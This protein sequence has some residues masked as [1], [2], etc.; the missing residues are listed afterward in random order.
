MRILFIALLALL[1]FMAEAKPTL[2]IDQA[3]FE[4]KCLHRGYACMYE[5]IHVTSK[6]TYDATTVRY[7]FIDNDAEYNDIVMKFVHS[8]RGVVYLEVKGDTKPVKWFVVNDNPNDE[9]QKQA[10]KS[11]Y[12]LLARFI[13]NE[14]FSVPSRVFFDISEDF[15]SDPREMRRIIVE[16]SR[17]VTVYAE[18]INHNIHYYRKTHPPTDTSFGGIMI[19]LDGW[20]EDY[21]RS[22]YIITTQPSWISFAKQYTQA[23][24]VLEIGS[25]RLPMFSGSTKKI[26]QQTVAWMA[27]HLKATY[28]MAYGTFPNKSVNDVLNYGGD[29]CK[30]LDLIFRQILKRSG[31]E[32][33]PSAISS[34]GMPP[35]SYRLIDPNWA[36]HVITYIPKLES[37]VDIT[38][39]MNDPAKWTE[40]ASEYTGATT[41]DLQTGRFAI[42]NVTRHL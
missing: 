20:T 25:D 2:T 12:P 32:S 19:N 40:S 13:S 36:D 38:R 22:F 15:E 17:K 21:D 9:N 14:K 33:Y 18:W 11:H 26:V 10:K 3:K 39:A 37:Y 28:G 23:D 42:V 24:S 5:L 29:E 30:G 16:V 35:R 7:L 27:T 31:I 34:V 41:L 8:H 1:P 6:N 4:Q